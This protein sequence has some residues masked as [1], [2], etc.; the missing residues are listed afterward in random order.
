M[1]SLKHSNIVLQLYMISRPCLGTCTA[2]DGAAGVGAGAGAGA[3]EG[4][5]VGTEGCTKK[6]RGRESRGQEEESHVSPGFPSQKPLSKA[7]VS[8][9]RRLQQGADDQYCSSSSISIVLYAA[10]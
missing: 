7:C 3:G 5:G 6:D 1:S 9:P 10:R 8:T 4:A 2:G